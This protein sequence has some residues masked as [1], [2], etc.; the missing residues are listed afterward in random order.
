VAAH[1]RRDSRVRDSRSRRSA[2]LQEARR[3]RDGVV[4]VAVA[5]WL[6]GGAMVKES[7]R[8]LLALADARWGRRRGEAAFSP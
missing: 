8:P 5:V 7:G 2:R 4:E 6:W 3:R 1:R